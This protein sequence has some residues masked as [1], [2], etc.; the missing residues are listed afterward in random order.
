MT[1]SLHFTNAAGCDSVATLH[2]TVKDTTISDT[3]VTK[4][5]NQLPFVW[6]GTN[7]NSSTTVS[8]HFTNAAG[9]DSVATLHF[10]VKDTTISD[11]TVT[12]CSNQLPFVW[13]GTNYNRSPT[14]SLHFTNA[15]GCD[16]VATL[17]FTVKDTT[18]SYT[19]VSKC[20][21]P[22]LFFWTFP[23]YNSSTTV[24]LHFTNAAGCDSVTT[25]HFTVKDTTISDTI[26]TK[27]SNQ[28]PFVWNGTNYNTSTTVSLHFTN[29]AGCEA[30][31][32]V[33]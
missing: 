25:L 31:T 8:L 17:H 2:F 11:T 27:C 21:T 12:K 5:S 16:S 9:C 28:L 19:I 13:N 3:I 33:L 18:I 7:Y 23:N 26:V 20:I 29:A 30:V 1:V 10:T 4:C 15:A 14:V 24:S 22:L 6:N 32:T